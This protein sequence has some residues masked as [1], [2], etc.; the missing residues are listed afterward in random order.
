MPRGA[1]KEGYSRRHR[2]TARGSFGPILKGSRKLR[3][4]FATG[5]RAGPLDDLVR[6]VNVFCRAYPL[7][8]QASPA[9]EPDFPATIVMPVANAP[10]PRPERRAA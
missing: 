6:L 7:A 2:F 4:R 10:N 8:S 1:R 3:G 5:L 9:V